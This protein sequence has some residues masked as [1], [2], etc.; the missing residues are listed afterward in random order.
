MRHLRREKG[1]LEAWVRVSSRRDSGRYSNSKGGKK[2]R[3]KGKSG[4][5]NWA[6][7]HNGP[8]PEEVQQRAATGGTL[9]L[10][11][12]DVLLNSGGLASV[13]KSIPTP[14][15]SR[16]AERKKKQNTARQFTAQR[17]ERAQSKKGK[18]D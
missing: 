6:P 8:R 4:Q 12:L 14:K 15:S 7:R 16:R 1:R 3:K 5:A 9:S 13:G 17:G 11:D 2:G 18:K 10:S